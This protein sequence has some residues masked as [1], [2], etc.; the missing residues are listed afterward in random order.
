MLAIAGRQRIPAAEQLMTLYD[1]YTADE[2]F[3]T[4]TMTGVAYVTEID[5]RAIGDGQPGPLS[6]RL[7]GLLRA[8]LD[9]T[10]VKVL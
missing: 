3:V 6:Q 5:G 10:G 8:Y 1:L 2:V 4:A 9:E 7:R